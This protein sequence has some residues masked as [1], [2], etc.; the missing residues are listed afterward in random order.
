MTKFDFT[1]L[2]NVG[3]A[4]SKDLKEI[5]IKDL[6]EMQK[7]G[8]EEIFFRHFQARGGWQNGMCSCWLYVIE[9]A[10]TATK[11]N[12][13]PQKR[14]DEFKKYVKDVRDSFNPEKR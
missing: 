6:K 4:I 1:K 3:K 12:E 9:G 2:M 8:T 14:K 7:L 11:W 13:I 10:I 5:G